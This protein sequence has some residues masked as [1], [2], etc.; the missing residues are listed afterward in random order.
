MHILI[1]SWLHNVCLVCIVIISVCWELI[2]IWILV[3]KGLARM[4][5]HMWYLSVGLIWESSMVHIRCTGSLLT[6][7]IQ[8][9]QLSIQ[10]KFCQINPLRW[11]RES[12][13]MLYSLI[14]PHTSRHF[15]MLTLPPVASP[16]SHSMINIFMPSWL[17]IQF[18][19]LTLAPSPRDTM[20]SSTSACWC[21]SQGHTLLL[22]LP[23]SPP[24]LY[25]AQIVHLLSLYT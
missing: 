4:N 25:N 22:D 12:D 10:A 15:H 16:L 8:F 3:R 21:I 24:Y 1:A 23:T 5:D 13:V 11:G 9:Y 7:V 6:N 2:V 20:I 18:N 17:W 19:V 14:R